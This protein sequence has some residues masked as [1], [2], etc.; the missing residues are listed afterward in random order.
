MLVRTTRRGVLI[1]SEWRPCGQGTWPATWPADCPLLDA[2]TGL[3]TEAAACPP[4]VFFTSPE[5]EAEVDATYYQRLER[6]KEEEEEKK[7]R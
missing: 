7:Q 5:I 1:P 3:P 4:L 6:L 2:A